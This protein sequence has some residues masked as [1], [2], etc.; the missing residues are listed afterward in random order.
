MD[1]TIKGQGS[2]DI[3]LRS[4]AGARA[5]AWLRA[6]AKSISTAEVCDTC[7]CAAEAYAEVVEEM[8][9]DAL[10]SITLEVNTTSIDADGCTAMHALHALLHVSSCANLN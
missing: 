8:S 10:A 7:K 5:N 6:Y 1:C 3:N 2:V 9:L 4:S